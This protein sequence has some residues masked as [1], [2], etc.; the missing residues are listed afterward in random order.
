M[1]IT[2]YAA[3]VCALDAVRLG[4]ALANTGAW[5]W[6]CCS[7][8]WTA[9]G[10]QSCSTIML[11][12]LVV[13]LQQCLLSGKSC[14]EICKLGGPSVCSWLSTTLLLQSLLCAFSGGAAV[15]PEHCADR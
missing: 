13:W 3:T 2:S 11:P 14:S 9:L 4:L 8:S 5:P 10:S 7:K 15:W 12:L 1:Q 6:P